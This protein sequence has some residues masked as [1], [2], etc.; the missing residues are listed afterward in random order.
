MNIQTN[1]HPKPVNGTNV[2]AHCLHV[3]TNLALTNQLGYYHQELHFLRA[4]L[5]IKIQAKSNDTH[6]T[7]KHNHRNPPRCNETLDA[8]KL[9]MSSDSVQNFYQNSCV[10]FLS[11]NKT[12]HVTFKCLLNLVVYPCASV[13]RSVKVLAWRVAEIQQ[14]KACDAKPSSWKGKGHWDKVKVQMGHTVQLC[15][16]KISKLSEMYIF[17]VLSSLW[18]RKYP[19]YPN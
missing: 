10:F 11:V 16:D 1:T 18:P 17:S 14:L 6:A 5:L 19:G 9:I 13:F 15:A 2:S 8:N 3:H 12:A 4:A 7:E